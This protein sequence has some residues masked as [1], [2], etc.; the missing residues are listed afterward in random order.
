MFM[1]YLWNERAQIVLFISHSY[2]LLVHTTS[3]LSLLHTTSDLSL[4]HT[5]SDL[6]LLHM[7]FCHKPYL[8]NCWSD[9]AT[10]KNRIGPG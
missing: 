5:T 10:Y 1:W 9:S 4:V 3:D 2:P 6:S 7:T 8:L